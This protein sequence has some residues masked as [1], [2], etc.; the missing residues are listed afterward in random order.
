MT[1]EK[2]ELMQPQNSLP[3]RAH[4]TQDQQDELRRVQTGGIGIVAVLLLIGLA[5][6]LTARSGSN[7]VA[8]GPAAAQQTDADGAAKSGE[9]LVELGVQPSTQKDA[10]AQAAPSAGPNTAP[11][12]VAP[13]PSQPV[14]VAP[15]GSVPDLK[16]DP[17]AQKAVRPN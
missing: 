10:P 2:T 3:N 12:I 13:P 9:P 11:A 7:P 14:P 15:D 6:T 4:R 17:N 1:N 8:S 16:P 5:S